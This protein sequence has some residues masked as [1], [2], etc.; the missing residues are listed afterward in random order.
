MNPITYIKRLH[1]IVMN[2]EKLQAAQ[3]AW[4][5]HQLEAVHEHRKETDTF[6]KSISGRTTRLSN[7]IEEAIKFIKDRTEVSADVSPSSWYP[8]N[9]RGTNTVIVVGRYKNNDYIDV[10]SLNVDS[11][12]Y[13]I[14]HL[15]ELNKH[16]EIHR[17]DAPEPFS[18]VIRRDIE[19]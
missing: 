13:L 4:M 7:R 19:S 9:H 18:A 11:F 12:R 15:R 5:L 6:V 8:R 16:G 2:F 17:I 1:D 14:E 3:Q 10:Y